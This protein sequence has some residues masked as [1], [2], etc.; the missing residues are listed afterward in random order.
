MA[1]LIDD[2]FYDSKTARQI[3]S[4]SRATSG[5]VVLSEISQVKTEIDAAA[6]G[7]ALRVRITDTTMT[8]SSVYYNAWQ[9]PRTYNDDPRNLARENMNRVINYLSRLGYM[10]MRERNGSL[11]LF[12]WKIFW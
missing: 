6:S 3:A 8:T 12:L 11:N 1:I 10:V 2:G 7:N 4:S 9:D 5:N